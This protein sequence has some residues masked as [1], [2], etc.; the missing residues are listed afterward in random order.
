MAIMNDL[1]ALALS[2]AIVIDTAA[3]G[4]FDHVATA[5]SVGAGEWVTAWL[6]EAPDAASLQLLTAVSGE[7]HPVESWEQDGSVV[8]FRSVDVGSALS[9]AAE[10]V[11]RKRQPMTAVGYP[12]VIDHPIF[13]LARASLDAERYLPYLCPWT[14]VGHLALFSAE[15]GYL[16]GRYYSGLRGAP[17]LAADGSVVGV[18]EDGS[19]AEGM[20]PL[21][22]FARLSVGAS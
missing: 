3:A 5:W 4:G 1:D 10:P 13:Q 15:E 20:P 18:V 22:R 21:T 19:D 16:T 7:V 14:L 2:L 12:S 9:V 6:G 8:G 17:V 11:L